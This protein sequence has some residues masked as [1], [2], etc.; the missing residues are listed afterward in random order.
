[1]PFEAGDLLLYANAQQILPLFFNVRNLR[2]N[3]KV[4]SS[5]VVVVVSR[6]GIS[7]V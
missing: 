5:V 4:A 7:Y 6:K 3:G 2:L 1:M